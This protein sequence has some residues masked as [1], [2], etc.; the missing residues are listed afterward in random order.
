M[1]KIIIMSGIPASGKSTITKQYSKPTDTILSRD[2]WRIKY[3]GGKYTPKEREAWHE[4]INAS[5]RSLNGDVWIDQTTL[6]MSSLAS[7]L[8]SINITANDEVIIYLLNT[9]LDE[10]LERN[11]KRSGNEKV[12]EKQLKHMYETHTQKPITADGIKAMKLPYK[13]TLRT[14]K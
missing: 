14:V 8:A 10:C 1:R 9:P 5:L 4:S 7:L 6:G 2:E 12:P 11:S 13:V 3:R